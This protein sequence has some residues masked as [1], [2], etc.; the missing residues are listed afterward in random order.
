MLSD[1]ARHSRFDAEE[2]RVLST[3]HPLDVPGL[4]RRI[5]GMLE[6]AERRTGRVAVFPGNITGHVRAVQQEAERT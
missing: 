4:H 6:D 1:I 5:R 2:F 3:E